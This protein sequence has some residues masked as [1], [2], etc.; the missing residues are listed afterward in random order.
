MISWNR[1]EFNFSI[2]IFWQSLDRLFTSKS[3]SKFFE[4]VTPMS[5]YCFVQIVWYAVE[6]KWLLNLVWKRSFK[7][8]HCC[9]CHNETISGMMHFFA[10]ANVFICLRFLCSTRF[11][12]CVKNSQFW[13]NNRLSAKKSPAQT[14]LD[15]NAAGLTKREFVD[16]TTFKQST[17]EF[18]AIF[19][20]I[21]KNRHV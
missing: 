21:Q 4:W 11:A 2:N 9:C 1:N 19:F 7:M 20:L 10:A 6:F 16:Y 13:L 5:L 8:H 12:W 17:R 18:S 15:K 3:T 14:I